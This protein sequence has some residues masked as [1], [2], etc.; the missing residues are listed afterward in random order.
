MSN[1]LSSAQ[2]GHG[3]QLPMFL[4]PQ[5]TRNLATNDF[6]G[7][8]VRHARK[9]M[10]NNWDQAQYDVDMGHI[11]HVS[12]GDVHTSE[13]RAGGV[14]EYLRSLKGQVRQAGGVERPVSVGLSRP[15]YITPYGT[16][17]GG[18]SEATLMDGHHRAIVA[19]ESKRLLPVEFW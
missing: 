15:P 8:R 4:T 14:R 5:E 2:F 13:V 9:N 16:V 19:S 6:P 18:R 10:Q 1:N 12:Q 17:H 3:D 7:D 11:D